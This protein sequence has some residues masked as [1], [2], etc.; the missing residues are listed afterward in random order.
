[1]L[2]PLSSWAY[3]SIQDISESSGPSINVTESNFNSE[4]ITSFVSWRTEDGLHH[5]AAGSFTGSIYI[6]NFHP[7]SLDSRKPPIII[8]PSD[9]N[10]TPAPSSPGRSPSHSR[11]HS[12][13]IQPPSSLSFNQALINVSAQARVVSGVSRE[14]VEAPKNYVDFEDEPGRLKDL[15]KSSS[16]PEKFSWERTLADAIF[17]SFDRGVVGPVIEQSPVQ[18]SPML[19]HALLTTASGS[20]TMNKVKDDSRSLLSAINS[21]PFSPLPLSAPPS[22]RQLSPPTDRSQFQRTALKATIILDPCGPGHRV[23]AMRHIEAKNLLIVLQ[24]SGCVLL[25]LT[26]IALHTKSLS[27]LYALDMRDSTCVATCQCTT[28]RLYGDQF[29]KWDTLRM[30]H[31]GDVRRFVDI[32]CLHRV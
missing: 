32:L 20:S 13:V 18:A 8:L 30:V 15:L 26:Y 24:E 12:K 1:M 11:R 31:S 4:Q 5:T 14:Q 7:P 16:K 29:W 10:S 28:T 25:L 2:L 17:P 22:P 23:S 21:P 27:K 6:F 19:P 3:A 9:H